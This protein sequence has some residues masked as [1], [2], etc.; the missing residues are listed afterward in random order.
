MNT[1]FNTNEVSNQMRCN[2]LT[3][4]DIAGKMGIST[5]GLWKKTTGRSEF[6]A[7]EICLLADLFHVQA[8]VFFISKVDT[9][10]TNKGA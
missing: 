6:K 3:K 7:S 9:S 10:S 1:V 4:E 5:V 8:G 2:N